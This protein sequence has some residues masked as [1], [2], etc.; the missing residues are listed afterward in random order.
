METIKDKTVAEIVTLNIKTADIFKK[1]GIDFCCGGGISVAKACENNNID[2]SEIENELLALDNKVETTQNYNEWG[3]DYLADYIVNTHHSYVAEAIPLLLQYAGRVAQVHGEH[4]T[5][6]VTINNLVREVAQELAAH[7]KKEEIMLFPYIKRLIAEQ[8]GATFKGNPPFGSVENPI[9][10][11]EE[12]HES[13]GDIFK[14]ISKL[15]HNYTP[16]E[17]ACN[18][19][20]AL[21]NKLDEFEQDLHQ[22]VHLENNILFPKAILLEKELLNS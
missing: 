1:H 5:Q 2:F 20:K 6:V 22:H 11:M 8:N 9:H 14:E 4:Y 21:Y 19:F 17:G 12:E 3:L 18:T 15:T 7:M 13:A 16:P 10:M